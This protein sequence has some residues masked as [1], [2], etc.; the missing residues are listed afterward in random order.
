MIYNVCKCD[1]C[2]QE[3]KGD[4][5]TVYRNLENGRVVGKSDICSSCWEKKQ[6]EVANEC[7]NLTGTEN[8]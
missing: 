1:V 5:F 6:F 4:Y 2:K 7:P 8:T 3:C